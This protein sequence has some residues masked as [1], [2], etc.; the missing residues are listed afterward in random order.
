MLINVSISP[1]ATR[2]ALRLAHPAAG[3]ALLAYLY[4]PT[5]DAEAIRSVVRLL[6]API[7]VATGVVLWKLPTIR[8]FLRR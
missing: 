4:A 7:V 3:I 1:R 6:A 2:Q 8:R 5:S